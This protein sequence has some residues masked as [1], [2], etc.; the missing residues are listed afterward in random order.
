MTDEIWLPIP[1]F[2]GF[3]VVS[4]R[5][6]VRSLPRPGCHNPNRIYGG[7]TIKPV[8]RKKDGYLVV[9]LRANGI[10][11]QRGLHQLVA[12]AFLGSPPEGFECCHNNGIKTDC[13][14]DNLRWDT[15]S[16]NAKDKAIHGTQF[17]GS[18]SP[19]AKLTESDVM[20]IKASSENTVELGKRFC[21]SNVTIG[22]IK[23][24]VTWR[25]VQLSGKEQKEA[26]GAADN[27][28]TFA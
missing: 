26:M 2:E 21:V 19:N 14:S 1:G 22:R 6:M 16:G 18:S 13:R 10:S 25:H 11:I 23:N 24:G 28:N 20:Q 3:Y 12:L 9:G 17:Y 15:K 8:L 4:N 5:G 27:M 7:K